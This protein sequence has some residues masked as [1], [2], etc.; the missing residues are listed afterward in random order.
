MEVSLRRQVGD[1]PVSTAAR[2]ES[3][4]KDKERT[5]VFNRTGTGSATTRSFGGPVSL[6]STISSTRP[7]NFDPVLNYR[8]PSAPKRLSGTATFGSTGFSSTMGSTL[9]SSGSLTTRSYGSTRPMT[10]TTAGA[11]TTRSFGYGTKRE[12]PSVF[13]S[14]YQVD[15]V[16]HQTRRRW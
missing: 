2:Q 6:S 12:D 10:T 16:P 11:Y 14:T 8:S 9:G 4:R 5:L 7:R 3:E 1:Q 15:F 13:K